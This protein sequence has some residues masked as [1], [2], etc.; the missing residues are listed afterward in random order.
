MRRRLRAPVSASYLAV[1]IISGGLHGAL[2]L[3]FGRPVG[4]AVF[5]LIFVALGLV[6]VGAIAFKNGRRRT[7]MDLRR[8]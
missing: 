6:G 3:V 8:T 4:A 5:F 1:W 7:L 2:F